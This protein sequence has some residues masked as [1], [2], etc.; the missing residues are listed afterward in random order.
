MVES[1]LYAL[2]V[3]SSP[4]SKIVLPDNRKE[5]WRA[6]SMDEETLRIVTPRR[7]EQLVAFIYEQLG[8]RSEVT[9]ATRDHGADVLAWQPGLFGTE[10][11]IVVQTKLY[12]GEN[13]VDLTG[14]HALHGAVTHYN[15]A[16]GHLVATTDVT[17]PAQQFLDARGYK[18]ID[19]SALRRE[20]DAILG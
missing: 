5:L 10:S 20:V 14:V 16:H 9:K 12:S 8:C 17:G 1:A 19:L 4:S 15:A 7:F 13:K 6:I 18:F 11:L 2:Y 3:A